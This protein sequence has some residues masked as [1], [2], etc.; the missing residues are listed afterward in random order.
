MSYLFKIKDIIGKN[1]YVKFLFY[2]F[3]IFITMSLEMIGIAMI[4]P[5]I[6]FFID[7][8]YFENEN[9]FNKVIVN[10]NFLGRDKIHI[11]V[12][13]IFGLT[14][15]IK[16][17]I[18]YFCNKWR[19]KFIYDLDY[20][21]SSKLLNTYLTQSYSYINSKSSSELIR[22]VQI[23]S[24][25]V[26][27]LN[28]IA[29]FLN[30]ALIFIAVSVVLIFFQSKA[31]LFIAV[32][33]ILIAL[34]F[35]FL[36]SPKL[37]KW[38]LERLE[39]EKKKLESLQSSFF[40]FKEIHV[41]DKKDT[42]LEKYKNSAKGWSYLSY[43]LD[44]FVSLPKLF[45]EVIAIF[46]FIFFLVIYDSIGNFNSIIPGLALFAVAGYKII[47]SITRILN[48]YQ[49]LDYHLPYIDKLH[50]EFKSTRTNKNLYVN[51]IK[52]KQSLELKNVF[53]KYPN[54]SD[55]I[56][57][58][59]NLR[60]DKGQFVGIYGR[61]GS[62]KSTLINIL[63][64][65]QKPESGSILLNNEEINYNNDYFIEKLGYVPQDIFLFNDTLSN[66]ISLF[67]DKINDKIFKDLI[68]KSQLENNFKFM[69]K[70]FLIG[71]RGKD[72]SGGQIQ[73]IAIA[74]SLYNNSN[75]LI[76][77]E[78]T[79]ALDEKTEKQFINTLHKLKN[80]KSMLIIS[81]DKE[82]LSICDII[83]ELCDYKL[84]KKNIPN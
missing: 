15:V 72:L 59:L 19:Y 30:E 82:V 32:I 40:G 60:I 49:F 50:S 21:Y 22:N 23:V 45:L 54:Q 46:F 48:S 6:S 26:Q 28:Q 61:S 71:E 66:N 35:N 57:K 81:H 18:L 9:F 62:G 75:L 27:C 14:F 68:E 58:N 24:I 5:I 17:I 13:L 34:I 39:Y 44:F 64:G 69:D 74:R 10:L 56:F 73:R 47:P 37:K 42:I 33:L 11:F 16:N 84:I 80:E 78:A 3:V 41:Y 2:I 29:L 1:N 63:L 8:N 7:S 53:F 36:T 67:D 52:Y 76:L 77:D 43:K 38:G 51:K 70:S 79:N 25:L 31:T 20:F 65:L 4:Y 83:Y 12:I 55:H